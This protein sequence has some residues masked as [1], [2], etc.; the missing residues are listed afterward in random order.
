MEG[1]TRSARAFFLNVGGA[2]GGRG[3]RGVVVSHAGGR[4]GARGARA[5]GFGG[6]DAVRDAA[7]DLTCTQES[8]QLERTQ[9]SASQRRNQDRYS[10]SSSWQMT[11]PT[12]VVFTRACPSSISV[13]TLVGTTV[14]SPLTSATSPSPP[15]RLATRRTGPQCSAQLRS[16][17]FQASAPVGHSKKVVLPLS[18]RLPSGQ[19]AKP[20]PAMAPLWGGSS[21]WSW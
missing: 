9:I 15:H 16:Y 10:P 17:K 19:T 1:Q 20:S 3:R 13:I 5:G 7:A 4:R 6:V 12:S 21:N 11:L 8:G 14:V 18:E 2:L